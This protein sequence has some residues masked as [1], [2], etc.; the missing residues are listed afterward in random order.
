M[1]ATRM[2]DSQLPPQREDGRDIQLKNKL[3]KSQVTA[4][5]AGD[6]EAFK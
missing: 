1:E 6:G 5:E 4:S 2:T 3:L